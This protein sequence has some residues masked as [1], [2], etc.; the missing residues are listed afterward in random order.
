MDIAILHPHFTRRGGAENVIAEI[1]NSLYERGHHVRIY[2]AYGYS[3][4][5]YP[6]IER[7]V[8]DKP[9]L[10]M[11]L[12]LHPFSLHIFQL[13][14]Y[15]S[16]S[17]P[18]DVVVIGGFPAHSAAFRAGH[19][20]VWLS[21]DYV[22]G[23]SDYEAEVGMSVTNRIKLYLYRRLF[24]RV[25]LKALG[26]ISNVI[27]NSSFLAEMLAR[28][29]GVKSV[30]IRP[31]VKM[32][33]FRCG[34]PGDYFLLVS[35]LYPQK[36]VELAIRAI[37]LLED[38]KLVLACIPGDLEYTRFVLKLVSNVDRVRIYIN[39]SMDE[40]VKLYSGCI[41][42]IAVG[43]NEAYGL[44]IL[45]AAASCKPTIAVGEG[46]YRELVING[47]T[48]LLVRPMVDDVAGAMEEFKGKKELS[49]KMGRNAYKL[50]MENFSW[51]DFIDKIEQHLLSIARR[52]E[53]KS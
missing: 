43:H 36:R 19:K 35:R 3:K 5:V 30:V 25:F 34:H 21:Q 41:A 45:E 22:P 15:M 50:I 23:L 11:G 4:L 8:V 29:Y 52:G 38:A 37:E 28:K 10:N 53:A 27:S 7:F 39:P 2:T 12:P 46:G 40:L 14:Y 49:E 48:G 31:G 51:E 13:L 20:C 24:K 44:T 18:E 42:N 9:P 32:E 47:V 6:E 26:R 17:Y 33:R 1:A 16:R